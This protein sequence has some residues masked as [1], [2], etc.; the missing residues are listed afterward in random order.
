M[1]ARTPIDKALNS[2]NTFAAFAGIVTAA[3]AW[4]IWGSDLFPAQPDPTGNPD[5]WTEQELRQ[6]LKNR[7]LHPSITATPAELLER[8]KANLRV[9]RV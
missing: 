1:P 7:N 5:N 2:R 6:W 3:A 4:S 9:P 8:V